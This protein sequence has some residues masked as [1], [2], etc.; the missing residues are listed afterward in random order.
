MTLNMCYSGCLR[1]GALTHAGV[2][3]VSNDT[4]FPVPM[5]GKKA[6]INGQN[7]ALLGITPARRRSL[8][9]RRPLLEHLIYFRIE[10]VDR[11]SI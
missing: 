3:L 10:F 4:N 11:C 5:N 7:I 8:L 1:N 9:V 2:Q 6:L